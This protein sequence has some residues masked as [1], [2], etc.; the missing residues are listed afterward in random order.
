MY[1]LM[2]YF[3]F[4]LWIASIIL[5]LTS[6][7]FYDPFEI[8]LSG[9][10]L[11]VICNLANLIFAKIFKART[12]LE[13]ASITALILTLIIGPLSGTASLLTLTFIGAVAMASKYVLKVG[14]KHIFNP[15]AIAVFL[16]A[17]LLNSGAS[18]WIGS[19][20]TLPVI[21]LGGFLL[22]A[23]IKRFELVASFFAIY[24]LTTILFG[25][26]ITINSFLVPPLWFFALV[27]LI[28][29]LTSPS[30]KS[31]QIIF[32]AF[33]A[34]VYFL[35][36]KIIPGYAYG[37]ETALLA[38]NLLTLVISP[39]FNTVFIF[40]R[41]DRV[42]ENTWTFYFEPMSKFDF[43]PG[44]YLEW[45]LPHKNPDK[46]G[47]R[48]YFTISSAPEESQVMLTIRVTNSGSS[49]KSALMKIRE[50]KGLVASGPQGN[51]VLPE[52]KEI[53]LVFIAGGI[54]VTPFRSMVK[55]MLSK[56]DK[57]KIIFLYL[58]SEEKD[59]A[60]K[61]LFE[62]AEA[63]GVRTF[64]INTKKDGYIGEK[65]I[66]EKVPD[67]Q[68]YTF[69][70]SGPELM[71]EAFKKMIAKMGVEKIKTDFFP[72]YKDTYQK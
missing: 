58:N 56:K 7:L 32:G 20:Y 2:L 33:V 42:A 62:K 39:S 64:Y 3:L 54:G 51:F 46:R 25:R 1:R 57:R 53:P 13:S 61:K 29:P 59:I 16:T 44:Q 36:P 47:I 28:E 19:I 52:D 11:G 68:K 48:R 31:K 22:L 8:F 26:S 38:G 41:K 6:T 71:V 9:V 4:V 69:Y 14:K 66:K 34:F 40:R 55:D 30:E 50:D 5:S 45:T 23:K 35:T 10:Y 17:I 43:T 18:W 37:L 70:I 21:I 24:F 27:M 49:F 67:Y 72:G 12:N 15:A 63:V 65:K 60:F